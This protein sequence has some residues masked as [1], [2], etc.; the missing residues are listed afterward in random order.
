MCW[1]LASLAPAMNG[2]DMAYYL[3]HSMG[4]HQDFHERD[5]VAA[6]NFGAAAKAAG[7]RRIM[8]LGGLGDPD[9]ALSQRL[10]VATG[11][12]ESVGRE[13]RAGH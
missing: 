8:Y 6:R 13:R 5:L 9:A 4:G 1:Y 12:G 7:V 3:V 10:R 11:Y 2:V